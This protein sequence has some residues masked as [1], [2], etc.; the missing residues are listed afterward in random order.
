M[1]API[2]EV[3]A[4]RLLGRF[5]VADGRG[6]VHEYAARPPEDRG[7]LWPSFP[8]NVFTLDGNRA[9]LVRKT[10]AYVV[11]DESADGSPIVETW[12]LRAHRRYV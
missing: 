12:R 8:H 4:K 9:A 7:G 2:T 5:S 10:V 1:F 3:Y 11:I 6:A